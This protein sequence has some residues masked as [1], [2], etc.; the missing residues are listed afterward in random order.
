M[1]HSG[2]FFHAVA[3]PYE[4][5]TRHRVWEEHCAQMARELPPA[6]RRVVDL[7]CGPGNSTAHLRSA[8]GAGAIGIDPARAMLARARRRGP[9]LSLVCADAAH[10]P[11]RDGSLDGVTLHSVLYLLPDRRAVLS[12]V[13]R[14]LRP[15]GRA[16]LL[17]PRAG[18]RT[19]ALGILRALPDPQW[20]LIALGWRTVSRAYGRFDEASLGALL[21]QAGLRVLKLEP[22]LGGLALLAVAE[23]PQAPAEE[24]APARCCDEPARPPDRPPAKSPAT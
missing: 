22:A 2:P 1:L 12:Q 8:I 24:P 17:E 11:V 23:R 15:G 7:G 14:A 18:F 21:E 10:L 6:A 4:L 19:T 3:R 20:A 9:D 5:L 13:A 16:A